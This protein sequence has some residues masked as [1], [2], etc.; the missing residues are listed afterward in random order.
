M[1]KVSTWSS[2]LIPMEPPRSSAQS[3][4]SFVELRSID[5]LRP[6]P[7]ELPSRKQTLLGGDTFPWDF[8]EV[9]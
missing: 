3:R 6:C 1:P 8:V 2:I 7:K 4:L 5:R 9:P